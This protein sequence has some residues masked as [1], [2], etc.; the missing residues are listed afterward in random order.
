AFYDQNTV[1]DTRNRNQ[2]F[3]ARL[4]WTPDSSNSVILQP[5]LYF[6]NNDANSLGG[7]ANT[8]LDG[9]PVS[10]A[11]SVSSDGTDGNNLSSRL[12][13]RH[14]FAKRGRNVSAEINAGHTLRDLASAQRSFTDYYSTS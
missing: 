10:T 6:Q 3:D 5:R 1:S 4:E 9:S 13:L 2:R 12:T 11:R 8:S 14:R 7:A